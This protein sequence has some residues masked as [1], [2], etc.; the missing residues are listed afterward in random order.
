MFVLPFPGRKRKATSAPSAPEPL[1]A[2][3]QQGDTPSRHTLV[4]AESAGEQRVAPATADPLHCALAELDAATEQPIAQRC[5]S[6]RAILPAPC[7]IMLPA[8]PGKSPGPSGWGAA[9][10][11]L[12]AAEAWS[13]P[14]TSVVRCDTDLQGPAGCDDAWPVSA[15]ALQSRAPVA[16]HTGAMVPVSNPRAGASALVRH[17]AFTLLNWVKDPKSLSCKRILWQCG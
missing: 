14:R 5:D 15:Q 8:V 3:S 6:F 2:P 9:T 1:N 16:S 4:P 13:P 10:A 7:R 11:G 12:A 17:I